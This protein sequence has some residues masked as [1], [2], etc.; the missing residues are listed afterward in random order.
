MRT[1]SPTQ[2]RPRVTRTDIASGHIHV[3]SVPLDRV[4]LDDADSVLAPAER[5]RAARIRHPAGRRRFRCARV[6]LR[7]VLA[8]YLGVPPDRPRFVRRCPEP[9]VCGDCGSGRPVLV[10]GPWPQVEFSLS[11]SGTAALIGV[12]GSPGTVGVDVERLRASFD[13]SRLPQVGATDRIT[14]FRTW[15]AVEAV[16]KAAGTG[17]RTPVSVREARAGGPLRARRAGDATEWY[18]HQVACP[19]GYVGSV[20]THTS[21]A[22][23]KTFLWT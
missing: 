14:G 16:G 20:A 19:E 4:P 8:G 7:T 15:T 23:L 22:I 6:A 1:L 13:W 10:P 21:D 12:V 3:W 17:L 11:H 9:E 5:A 2:P 18:V